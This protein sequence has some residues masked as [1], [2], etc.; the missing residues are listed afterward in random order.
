[1]Y[2]SI[3][4]DIQYSGTITSDGLAVIAAAVREAEIVPTASILFVRIGDTDHF[5][6]GSG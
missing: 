2:I 1:M 4:V 5:A 3:V 6:S